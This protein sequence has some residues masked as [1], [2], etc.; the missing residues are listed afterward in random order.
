[1]VSEPLLWPQSP[2]LSEWLAQGEIQPSP[3]TLSS[4]SAKRE[5]PPTL[6]HSP[7]ALKTRRQS[8][9]LEGHADRLQDG[10]RPPPGGFDHGSNIGVEGGTPLRSEAVDDLSQGRARSQGTLGAVV[11]RRN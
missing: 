8:P 6:F 2:S 5:Q 11:A 4:K 1:M 7:T 3:F 9:S 10:D